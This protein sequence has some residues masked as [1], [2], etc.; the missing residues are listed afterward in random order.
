MHQPIEGLTESLGRRA[1]VEGLARGVRLAGRRQLL[2]WAATWG[3]AL[4]VTLALGAAIDWLAW[5]PVLTLIL[6]LLALGTLLAARRRARASVT[7][8]DLAPRK[9]T[10]R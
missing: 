10:S 8:A 6:A 4:A 3:A 2:R 1:E 9:D 7:R 5:A